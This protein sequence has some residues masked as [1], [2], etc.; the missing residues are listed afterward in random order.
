MPKYNPL[1]PRVWTRVESKCTYNETSNNTYVYDPLT[2]QNIPRFEAIIKTQ[3]I[4]KGNVLQYKKNS[5][6]LTKSQRYSQICKGM[7]T[8]RTKNYATQSDVYTNPNTTSLLRENSIN[9][10]GTNP[11][12]NPFNCS[13]NFIQDGGNLVCNVTVNPCTN[14]VIRTTKSN[15]CFSNTYSDV[16]GRATILCWNPRIQTWYAK[17]RYIMNNSGTK[18]PINYKGFV[19]A[20]QNPTPS[21]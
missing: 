18:W 14:E 12:L 20:C 9:I 19:S 15:N 10:P 13:T 4:I 7:W 8:N 2:K 16:P 11:Y 1:P 5:S 17:P 21:N 3:Q 6:S